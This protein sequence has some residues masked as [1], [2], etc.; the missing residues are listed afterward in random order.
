MKES[1]PQIELD[2][3]TTVGYLIGCGH[4]L[5]GKS[6]LSGLYYRFSNSSDNGERNS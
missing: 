5:H 3:G 1:L 4:I 6:W 2:Y